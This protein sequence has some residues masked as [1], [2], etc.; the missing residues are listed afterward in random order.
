LYDSLKI[1]VVVGTSPDGK[2]SDPSELFPSS[3]ILE[4]KKN[5]DTTTDLI[6]IRA[7]KLSTGK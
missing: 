4:D 3:K 6:R 7:S 2:I 1:R 5:L